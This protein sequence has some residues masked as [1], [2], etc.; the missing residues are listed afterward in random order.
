MTWRNS[1]KKDSRAVSPVV[2]GILMI[3]VVI[4]LAVVV[5]T[6]VTGFGDKLDEPSPEGTFDY[7][8]VP[9]GEDNTD[10]R[11]YVEIS[12]RTGENADAED[13]EIIDESGNSVTWA[14]VWTGGPEVNATEYVH[15]DGFGSD[16]ALDP[17]C[18]EGDTYTVVLRGDD[19]TNDIVTE[20]TAPTDP[21]LPSGSPSDSNG[22]GIP[23]WC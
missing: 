8:Y 6:A 19:G 21:D 18:E 13:I 20:W 10:D 22:D 23:D 17:I 3:A 7:E 11:P 16:G 9:T 12:Y 5:A 2:G 15:I 14:A 4:L 1:R